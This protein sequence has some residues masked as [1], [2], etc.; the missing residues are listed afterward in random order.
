[1][2]VTATRPTEFGDGP[3]SDLWEVLCQRRGWTPEFLREIECDDHGELLGMTDMVVALHEAHTTGSRIVIA[4]D[5]DMDGIASGVLGYAG[6]AE[7]G[8]VVDLHI[9]DYERGHDL[10]PE[11]VAEIHRD[12]PDTRV[13]LTCDGGVN[14]H[15]GIDAAH[16]YGWTVLITDHHEELAP[17]STADVIVNPCRLDET[18]AHPGI[19]GAH[20]L[21]QVLDTYTRTY[22]PDKWWEIHLLRLFAGLGTVADVMPVVYENR[23]LIRDSLSIARL[24]WMPPQASDTQDDSTVGDVSASTLMQLIMATDHHEVFCRVFTGFAL[25]LR[26]FTAQGLLQDRNSVDEQFYG[27]SLAPTMNAPRRTGASLRPCFDT[28]LA[29]TPAQMVSAIRQAIDTNQ[30]R[31]QLTATCLDQL[32]SSVQSFAPWVYVTDA[33]PGMLGLLANSLMTQTGHPVVVMNRASEPEGPVSGSARAPGWCDMV[34]LVA[35]HPGMSGIGHQQACG[36]KLTSDRLCADLAGRI[37]AATIMAMTTMDTTT[38]RPDLTLGGEPECDGPVDVDQLMGLVQRCDTVRP[39]GHGFEA[40]LIELVM[41][42]RG[43]RVDRIGST[44]QHVRLVTPGGLTC[45]WWN[46]ATAHAEALTSWCVA[47][48]PLRLITRCQLNTFRD[49]TRVQAIVEQ[50]ITDV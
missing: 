16:E 43:V 14:S 42:S 18:Y 19:C 41:D 1:M 21:W 44:R 23:S 30:V 12:H 26:E 48:R 32:E 20:V 31:K 10:T 33:Y 45:L 4:P 35:D 7:L 6:L 3:A 9:P 25:L 49:V 2:T 24:L 11:D 47:A 27:F 15:R 17:R 13:L 5:F 22:C 36:I 28:F 40:P 37:Q 46:A 39:F 34:S 8:F 29:S 50:W 38:T